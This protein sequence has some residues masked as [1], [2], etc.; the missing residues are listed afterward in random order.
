MAEMAVASHSLKSQRRGETGEEKKET[1][2]LNDKNYQKSS[3]KETMALKE[4]IITR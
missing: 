4:H 1:K 3:I 2:V